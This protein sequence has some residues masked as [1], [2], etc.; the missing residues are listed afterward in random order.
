[1]IEKQPQIRLFG[2]GGAEGRDFGA[3]HVAE[4]LVAACPSTG[5]A[6][7]IRERPPDPS[8]PCCA[9]PCRPW[10]RS[11]RSAPRVSAAVSTTRQLQAAR[12]RSPRRSGIC[13]GRPVRSS[14]V[15]LF[16]DA[17][18]ARRAGQ[19][20]GRRRRGDQQPQREHV[21]RG[22]EEVVALADADRLQRRAQR[23]GAAEQ[24]RRAR[25]RPAGSSARRSPAPRPSGPGRT[26][27]PR[28]SF[29]DRTATDRPRRCRPARRRRRSTG[30]ARDRRG[31]PW[32][33]PRRC[34]RRRRG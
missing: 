28:S 2:A 6:A 17:E 20:A 21:G 27:C 19:R 22:V 32:R 13:S 5:R 1:M 30:C 25:S 14:P 8:S 4:D 9:A 33:A 10:R 11:D 23:A 31:C 26:R 7:R 3:V 24:Q 29:P 34:C 15:L 12:G 16:G 18:L